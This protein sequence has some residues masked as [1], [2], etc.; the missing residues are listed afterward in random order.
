MFLLPAFN[1]LQISFLFVHFHIHFLERCFRSWNF[2]ALQMYKKHF[3]QI[4]RSPERSVSEIN[5]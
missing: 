4:L 1:I 2:T 3:R 5:K